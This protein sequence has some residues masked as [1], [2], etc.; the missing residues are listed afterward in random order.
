MDHYVLAFA[1]MIPADGANNLILIQRAKADWQQGMLNLPGGQIHDDEFIEAAAFR[2]LREE[3]GIIASKPDIE[4]LGSIMGQ[5][6]CRV[7]VCFCPYRRWHAGIE[8]K[9]RTLTEEG[10]VLSMPWREAMKDQRLV[11]NLRLI[12]P[13]CMARLTGWAMMQGNQ[14]WEVFV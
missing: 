4:V 8:Q 1:H 9:P 2:E 12:I 5:S 3:T 10:T 6:G 13:L 7:E 11:P 14:G